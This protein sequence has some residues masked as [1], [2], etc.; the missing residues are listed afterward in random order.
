MISSGFTI[1][2]WRKWGVA[3][4]FALACFLSAMGNSENVRSNGWSRD[5]GPGMVATGTRLPPFML[6]DVTGDA[7]LSRS[8][9]HVHGACLFF[10]YTPT[11]IE[12]DGSEASNGEFYPDVIFHVGNATD[13]EWNSIGQS[14]EHGKRLRMAV[15]PQKAS[16]A[17]MVELDVFRPMIGKF[18]YGRIVLKNGESALFELENLLPPKQKQ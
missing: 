4:F 18:K 14:Y 8:D 16:K 6:T 17:L 1:G 10:N 15:E 9:E 3:P 11:L 5:L 12:I 13:G 2:S 7:H